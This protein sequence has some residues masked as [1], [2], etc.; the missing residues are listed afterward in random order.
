M[1]ARYGIADGDRI[2]V[3]SPRGRICLKAKLTDG[4]RPDTV[5]VLH[6]WEEA[7]ANLL[8]DDANCD[9]ILA[10]PPLRAGLCR[11]AKAEEGEAR[12]AGDTSTGSV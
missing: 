9:P 12:R 5:S 8:T 10:C 6:G 4:I 11:V 7:N 2:E 1:A 3:S